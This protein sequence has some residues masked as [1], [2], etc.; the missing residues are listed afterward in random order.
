MSKRVATYLFFLSLLMLGAG[1]AMRKYTVITVSYVEVIG[2][3]KLAA[4]DLPVKAGDNLLNVDMKGIVNSA[5]KHNFV[6]SA[7]AHAD[8]YG[9]VSINV[10]EK[11]PVSYVYINRLYGIT[12]RCE[13]LPADFNDE[14]LQLP[15][16]RGV[17][18]KTPVCFS[19]VDDAALRAAVALVETVK[20]KYP[21]SYDTLSEI[22]IEGN[23]LK[24]IIEPG[25]IVAHLGWGDIERKIQRIEQI[26]EKNKN[27][28]LDIDLRLGEL[29]VLKSRVSKDREVNNGI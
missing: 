23:E 7:S 11:V 5:M 13:L 6:A 19:I 26:L 18:V 14:G 28:G 24:L 29:A 10:T 20:S 3:D 21:R 17:K 15:I 4:A 25:S 2:S 8:Q 1:F 16:I 27:P 12:N 22:V 9:K